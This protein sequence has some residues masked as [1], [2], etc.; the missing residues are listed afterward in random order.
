MNRNK[1]NTG[2]TLIELLVVI[3]I[4]G[5][6]ASVVMASLNSARTKGQDAA[7][8]S[9]MAEM[10]AQA[11]IFQ[12][13]NGSFTGSGAANMDDSLAECLGSSGK[14]IGTIFDPAE[15]EGI[16]DLMN[17]VYQNSSGAPAGARVFCAVYPNSWAFAAGLHN[18]S[19]SNTGWCVDSQGAAKEVAFSFNAVG[20]HLASGGLARCP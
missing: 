18:P 1:Q 3:A 14:F 13:S 19:G 15:S 2:F 10:R 5:I 12:L 17:G 16:A 8:K 7:I 20:T 11:A 6:L 4:I 9:Q